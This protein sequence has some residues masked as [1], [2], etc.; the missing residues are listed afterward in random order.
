MREGRTEEGERKGGR[1]RV[2]NR[3]KKRPGGT[4]REGEGEIKR[5]RKRN[6]MEE[7]EKEKGRR[8]ETYQAAP[9]TAAKY[10]IEATKS[11]SQMFCR[12]DEPEE[13]GIGK[14]KRK[15][16][17]EKGREGDLLYLQFRTLRCP[18]DCLKRPRS[19]TAPLSHQ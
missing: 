13:E 2:K 14:E 17:K 18:T 7:K 15:E 16:E 5:K 3:T 1:E 6:C 19:Y 9:D 12:G 8:R 10:V 4:Q 11:V